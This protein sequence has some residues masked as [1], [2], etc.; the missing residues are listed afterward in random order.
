MAPSRRDNPSPIFMA[1][2]GIWPIFMIGILVWI[3]TVTDGGRAVFSRFE[4]MLDLPQ[5]TK[6]AI[7]GGALVL[8]VLYMVGQ[9]IRNRKRFKKIREE[10]EA[11]EIE[12]RANSSKARRAV[13]AI[14]TEIDKARDLNDRLPALVESAELHVVQAKQFLQDDDAAS[15]DVE[16]QAATRQTKAAAAALN[17]ILRA[18]STHPARLET[19]VK[20]GSDMTDVDEE[21]PVQVDSALVARVSALSEQIDDWTNQSKQA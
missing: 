7:A 11:A 6:F 15:F 2:M 18:E 14:D 10:R 8:L 1:F 13:E 12:R 17:R 21:F 9:T 4:W 20:E 3:F 16:F 19:A 5:A